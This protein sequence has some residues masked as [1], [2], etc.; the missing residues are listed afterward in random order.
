MARLGREFGWP[1]GGG[2]RKR[3]RFEGRGRTEGFLES[4]G[5]KWVLG[6]SGKVG[7]FTF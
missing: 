4:E 6:L 2:V 5:E 1:G 7:P 3:S